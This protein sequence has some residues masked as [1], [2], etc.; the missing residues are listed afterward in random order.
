MS[1]S[2]FMENKEENISLLLKLCKLKQGNRKL[3]ECLIDSHD[4]P[5]SIEA[6]VHPDRTDK[7]E[8]HEKNWSIFIEEGM[9]MMWPV[10]E[11]KRWD[12][13]PIYCHI[14]NY[15]ENWN[16]CFELIEEMRLDRVETYLYSISDK[17]LNINKKFGCEIF[18]IYEDY[19]DTNF[20]YELDDNPKACIVKIYIQY[21]EWANTGK[22][23]RNLKN[24]H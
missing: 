20:D 14:E 15:L 13:T 5:W 1:Y 8:M 10:Y 17:N 22:G 24:E 21:K 2:T 4:W 16:L 11:D 3:M 19:P 23:R 7:N 9:G 12:G 18:T 6:P